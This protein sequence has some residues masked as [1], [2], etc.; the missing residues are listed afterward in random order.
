[1]DYDSNA[2]VDLLKE[3]GYVIPAAGGSV[4]AKD[5]KALELTLSFPDDEQH[6]AIAEQLKRNWDEIGFNVTLEAVPYDEL[7]NTD[8]ET[9]SFQAA[10]A[11]LNL[12]LTPD[13]DPYPFWHQSEATGGQNYSQWDDRTASEYIEQ[14]RVTTDLDTRAR[15]YRNFQVVFDKAATRCRCTS[16]FTPSG[17]ATR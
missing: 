1:V 17:S 6:L 2:A 10:L 5:G 12:T 9:R 8:L 13:P 7:I 14:A 15:L 4:R 16:R 11:D 3:N